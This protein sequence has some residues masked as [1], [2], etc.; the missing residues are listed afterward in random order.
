MTALLPT[1][2]SSPNGTDPS[3]GG[4]IA[5]VAPPEAAALAAA[6][7]QLE[8]LA[9]ADHHGDVLTSVRD[10]LQ[11][12]G[13]YTEEAFF[14]GIDLVSREAVRR[15]KLLTLKVIAPIVHK[16]RQTKGW[17]RMV[18]PQTGETYDDFDQWAEIA[19][20]LSHTKATNLCT[21]YELVLPA[22]RAQ[23][24][25]ADDLEEVDESKLMLVAP[26]MKE[27]QRT[28]ERIKREADLHHTPPDEV[29]IPPVPDVA[30]I[31]NYAKIGSWQ[32]VRQRVLT[33]Q[34]VQKESVEVTFLVGRMDDGRYE[35]HA[36]LTRAE[37]LRL[38]ERLRP[39]WLELHTQLPVSLH[40]ELREVGEVGGD[41]DPESA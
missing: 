21:V 2:P 25:T 33:A 41:G 39:R 7:P 1:N 19:L 13:A 14:A 18:N 22:A 5:S 8:A 28:V 15:V 34:G 10:L 6:R 16:M 31:I 4:L 23:G 11:A 36:R 30:E 12:Q 37:M 29:Q 40:D 20:G 27:H 38:D 3:G 9:A 26:L 24:L 35:V 17:V 32:E